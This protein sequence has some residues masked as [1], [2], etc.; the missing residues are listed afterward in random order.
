[1]YAG[2]RFNGYSHLLGLV[3]AGVGAML[4][5]DKTLDAGDA[6]RTAAGV[7]FSLSML[8]LYSASTMFHSTR[9]RAKL[10]WRRADHCAI[11]LLIAGTYTPLALV[12]LAGALGWVLFCAVWSAALWGIARE[13]CS[14]EGARP[15]LAIYVG[16]GWLGLLAAAPIVARLEA[17]GLGWLVAGAVLY[18]AGTI[19]YR[20]PRGMRHAHGTWHLF[21]LAGTASHYV[22]I[23]GFIL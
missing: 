23:A 8:A 13:L 6:A 5:L 16:M 7:V 20:N 12:T 18:T 11:Y 9:G 17:G 2:E 14:S 21:V 1:V 4:L 3:L 19:F 10:F 15:A 22:A